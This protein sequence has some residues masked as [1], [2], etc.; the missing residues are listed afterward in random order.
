MTSLSTFLSRKH[1]LQIDQRIY[2]EIYILNLNVT[3]ATLKSIDIQSLKYLLIQTNIQFR[4]CK[5]QFC[6]SDYRCICRED[7]YTFSAQSVENQTA[8]TKY[9]GRGTSLLLDCRRGWI[10]KNDRVDSIGCN[11][12]EHFMSFCASFLSRLSVHSGISISRELF[13]R[14]D[15]QYICNNNL[16]F[17]PMKKLYDK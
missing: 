7:G 1:H 6:A 13:A 3:L 9:A 15:I 12:H 16:G 8:N 17:S 14:L 5:R 10:A 2:A 11:I 4:R